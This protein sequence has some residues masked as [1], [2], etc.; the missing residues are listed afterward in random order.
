M[1]GK[2]G[3]KAPAGW[4]R[5]FLQALRIIPNVFRAC[6]VSR[7]SP[8]TVYKARKESKKFEK[9]WDLA[10]ETGYALMEE[11]AMRLA[12]QGNK[13]GVWKVVNGV[14]VKVEVLTDYSE[15]MLLH[16]LR[17]HYPH[18]REQARIEHVGGGP[19]TAPI[20]T[21]QLPPLI[22]KELEDAV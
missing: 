8:P 20:Q 17:V 2:N 21:Q 1:L 18:H 19:G 4:Q 12:T 6:R 16:L 3:S 14:P 5:K 13:R 11:T 10:L 22:P 9:A 15:A 7:V